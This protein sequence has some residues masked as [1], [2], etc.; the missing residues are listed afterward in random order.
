MGDFLPYKLSKDGAKLY[1]VVAAQVEGA[2]AAVEGQL[3]AV[4]AALPTP[5]PAL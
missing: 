1:A 5:A 2:E 4:M 3:P